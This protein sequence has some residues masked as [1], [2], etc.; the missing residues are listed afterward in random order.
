M[1]MRH[2]KV[3]EH[4]N[5]TGLSVADRELCIDFLRSLDRSIQRARLDYKKRTGRWWYS[6]LSDNE[7]IHIRD[8]VTTAAMN[9]LVGRQKGPG[10]LFTLEREVPVD[11]MAY[12]RQSL[13]MGT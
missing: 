4:P 1:S 6:E 10:K 5:P 9:Q 3:K 12:V 11:D 8:R 7:E 2:V 13:G